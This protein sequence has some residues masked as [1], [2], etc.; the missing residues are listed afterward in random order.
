[1]PLVFSL[2]LMLFSF[3]FRKNRKFNDFFITT[4]L[5]FINMGFYFL[6]KNMKKSLNFRFFQKI[7]ENYSKTNTNKG[8]KYTMNVN[9]N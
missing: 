6:D 4:N 1:M 3:I 2:I 5:F 7:I 8:R 9:I